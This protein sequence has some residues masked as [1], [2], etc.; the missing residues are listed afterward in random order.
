[1]RETNVPRR[2]APKVL[3]REDGSVGILKLFIA[4]QE[5]LSR[6]GICE[7]YMYFHAHEIW[8]IKHRCDCA[9]SAIQNGSL[10]TGIANCKQMNVGSQLP[11]LGCGYSMETDK[12][13]AKMRNKLA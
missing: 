12:N 2:T 7:T 11:L 1:M 13:L 3:A 6:Y 4:W 8:Y 9:H 5:E 10:G